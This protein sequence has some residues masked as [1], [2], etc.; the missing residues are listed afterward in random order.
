MTTRFAIGVSLLVVFGWSTPGAGAATDP[1][2]QTTWDGLSVVVGQKVRV[3]MPDGTRIEGKAIALE[4][5]ALAV[6]IGKTSNKE[7]YPKGSFLVPRATLRALDLVVR[8]TKRWRIMS[9]SAGVIVG[10]A[11]G[12]VAVDAIRHSPP[13]ATFVGFG[14]AAIA[15]PVLGYFLG[16]AADRR[17]ITFLITP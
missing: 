16:R 8:S 7:T 13:G 11:F 2:R 15:M 14:G 10:S 5:D 4:N 12:I 3:V 6:D 9:V 17:S 1:E